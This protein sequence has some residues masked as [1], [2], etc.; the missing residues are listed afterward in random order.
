MPPRRRSKIFSNKKGVE[1]WT[2]D[3]LSVF[4]Q[5]R[6]QITRCTHLIKSHQHLMKVFTSFFGEDQ[7]H[8][9]LYRDTNLPYWSYSCIPEPTSLD[10]YQK[11]RGTTFV[12]AASPFQPRMHGFWVSV[13][14]TSCPVQHNSRII[15]SMCSRQIRA[16]QNLPSNQSDSIS[17]A[18]WFLIFLKQVHA[19]RSWTWNAVFTCGVEFH[20]MSKILPVS[21]LVGTLRS[22][23]NGR[24]HTTQWLEVGE[25]RLPAHGHCGQEVGWWVYSMHANQWYKRG[26][27]D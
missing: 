10:H 4:V 13:E 7:S 21:G 25:V 18:S 23:F 22:T 24:T 1:Q 6:G 26:R 17:W 19:F 8:N 5:A 14:R 15:N 3:L 27:T 2:L 9:P 16:V 20:G 11:K 12:I